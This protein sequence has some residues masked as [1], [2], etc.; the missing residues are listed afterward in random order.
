MGYKKPV[1]SNI[2]AMKNERNGDRF[3]NA[4]VETALPDGKLL[5]IKMRLL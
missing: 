4:V 3:F 2:T 1:T 5:P